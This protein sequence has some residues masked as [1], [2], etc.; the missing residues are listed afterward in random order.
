MDECATACGQEERDDIT[1]WDFNAS[2]FE[3]HRFPFLDVLL[4]FLNVGP[5]NKVIATTCVNK[6]L[7]YFG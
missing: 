7:F 6:P 1:R 4:D 3:Y 5:T 2:R